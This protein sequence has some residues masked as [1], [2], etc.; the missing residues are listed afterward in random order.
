MKTMDTQKA[1]QLKGASKMFFETTSCW[2][3][4]HLKAAWLPCCTEDVLT[5]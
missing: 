4:Y 3:H 1:I 5:L 2:N